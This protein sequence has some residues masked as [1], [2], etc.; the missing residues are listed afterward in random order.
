M[1]KSR[2]K[3]HGM[4]KPGGDKLARVPSRWD[5]FA[6]GD[7]LFSLKSNVCPSFKVLTYSNH[8]VF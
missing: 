3:W 8:S 7:T 4:Y 2:S 1:W 6:G 5:I